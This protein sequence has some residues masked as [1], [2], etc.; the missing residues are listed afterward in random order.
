MRDK[1]AVSQLLAEAKDASGD[2]TVEKAKL[3]A[4]DT[5]PLVLADILSYVQTNMATKTIDSKSIGDRDL[6]EYKIIMNSAVARKLKMLSL[7]MP[8]ETVQEVFKSTVGN[9]KS[10]ANALYF[11]FDGVD[12]IG[13]EDIPVD[14]IL[15][16]TPAFTVAPVVPVMVGSDELK[17]SRNVTFG[18]SAAVPRAI[19]STS[20]KTYQASFSSTGT[21]EMDKVKEVKPLVSL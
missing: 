3:E 15:L 11:D 16:F 8:N 21:L 2:L 1:G 4:R 12:V 6:T 14:K 17:K 13:V 10:K 5:A 18:I 7:I 20:K 9:V 19:K